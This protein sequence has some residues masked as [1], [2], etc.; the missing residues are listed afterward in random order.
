MFFV[1]LRS[2]ALRGFI[3]DADL[4]V[5][6][7]EGYPVSFFANIHTYT[8]LQTETPVNHYIRNPQDET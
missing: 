7:R 5:G 8:H 3:F 6:H 4:V 1:S 2:K